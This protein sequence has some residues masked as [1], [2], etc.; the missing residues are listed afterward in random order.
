VG[1]K[2]GKNY[3]ILHYSENIQC[4][5]MHKN[6]FRFVTNPLIVYTD[7][8]D[9]YAFM[10][11]VRTDFQKKTKIFKIERQ[12]LWA[13]QLIDKIK[14]VF[15]QPG[16]PKHSPNTIMP[17]Y[18]GLVTN[19]YALAQFIYPCLLIPPPFLNLPRSK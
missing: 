5:S 3:Y 19:L 9:F 15:S 18:N 16:Y 17:A 11:K 13:F 2:A 7:S 10:T 1:P 6:R 4:Q 8:D 14:A 12:S